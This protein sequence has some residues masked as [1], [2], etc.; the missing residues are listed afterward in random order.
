MDFGSSNAVLTTKWQQFS[1]IKFQRPYRQTEMSVRSFCVN[2][3]RSKKIILFGFRSKEP[4]VGGTS[5]QAR[6]L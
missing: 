3:E 2:S 1:I 5:T 6:I 4:R